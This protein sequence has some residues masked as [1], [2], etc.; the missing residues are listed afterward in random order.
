MNALA[1]P[2]EPA[3]PLW[4]SVAGYEEACAPGEPLEGGART[5]DQNGG[6]R[7]IQSQ[8]GSFGTLLSPTDPVGWQQRQPDGCEM[9]LEFEGPKRLPIA[10]ALQIRPDRDA[11]TQLQQRTLVVGGSRGSDDC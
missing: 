7:W 8:S 9:L 5:P 11:E 2:N 3:I 6:Q 4:E 10:G 1:L